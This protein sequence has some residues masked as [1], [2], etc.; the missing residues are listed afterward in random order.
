MICSHWEANMTMYQQDDVQLARR[1]AWL[2]QKVTR[3][4]RSVIAGAAAFMA[5]QITR[6]LFPDH[7]DFIAWGGFVVIW[8]VLSGVVQW[9]EFRNAPEHIKFID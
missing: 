3:L 9:M 4:L 1:I 5:W 6:S 8:L 7:W 2:E